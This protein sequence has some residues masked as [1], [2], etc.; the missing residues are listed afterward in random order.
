M[1][2]SKIFVLGILAGAYI[3][4]GA[5]LMMMVG[6]RCVGI[7]AADPGL[8]AIISGLFG[9]PCGL[10][11]VIISGAELFT[12][13]TAMVTAAMLEGE[14]DMGGLAKSWVVSYAGNLAGSVMLAAMA[15]YAGLFA[16]GQ[17]AVPMSVAKTSMA[18]GPALVKGILCNWL[19]CMAIYLANAADT[20]T[21]K[22][23]AVMF[24]IPAF[25]AIGLEH[26]VANM[27]IIP[28]GILAGS[29]VTWGEFFMKNL[30]PVTIGNTIAGAVFVAFLLWLAYKK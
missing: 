15:V 6:G 20:L 11:M 7:G 30:I 24:P 22:A 3:G 5:L 2:A 25:V 29:G 14:V 21:G 12:G 23:A 28:A 8:K 16:G 19:V 10:M 18:F 27:F 1:P 9:L 13:N 17:P 4:L 26:S